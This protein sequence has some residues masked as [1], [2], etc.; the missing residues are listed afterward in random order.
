MLSFIAFYFIL[1]QPAI[2]FET[3]YLV[4]DH[5]FQVI[6]TIFHKAD[7]TLDTR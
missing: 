6:D 3:K 7:F 5:T 1:F 4:L 2:T